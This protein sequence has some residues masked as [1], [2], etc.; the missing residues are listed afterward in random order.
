M[1]PFMYESFVQERQADLLRQADRQRLVKAASELKRGRGR[2]RLRLSGWWR[3]L[4]SALRSGA[5]QAAGA[6][7]TSSVRIGARSRPAA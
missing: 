5:R 4:G 2:R 3:R 7:L 6:F 1:H